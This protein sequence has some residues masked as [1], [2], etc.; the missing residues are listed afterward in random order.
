LIYDLFQGPEF[1][2]WVPFL[3]DLHT[4]VRTSQKSNQEGA[5]KVALEIA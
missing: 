1:V 2:W 5:F 4:S 3:W